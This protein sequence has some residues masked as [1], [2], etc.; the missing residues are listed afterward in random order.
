M[1]LT[2]FV[3][4]R[5]SH[6]SGWKSIGQVFSHS[7]SLLRSSCSRTAPSLLLILTYK[8]LSPANSLMCDVTQSGISLMYARNS[9]GPNTVP[10]GTPDR[11][12]TVVDVCH[13]QELL[14]Y[15]FDG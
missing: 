14:G 4:L 3:F 7:W 8:R 6:L 5:I 15:G 10:C 13:L 12:G 2:L 9:S 1:G 11:T